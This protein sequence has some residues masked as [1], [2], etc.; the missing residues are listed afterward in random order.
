MPNENIFAE[1]E[2]AR[3]TGTVVGFVVLYCLALR[4]R[5]VGCFTGYQ[6][7]AQGPLRAS[8]RLLGCVIFTEIGDTEQVD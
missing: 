5:A 8:N 6:W 4:S 7:D 2:K 1:R 3:Q